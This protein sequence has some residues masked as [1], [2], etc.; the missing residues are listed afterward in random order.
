[1]AI[2]SSIAASRAGRLS[3]RGAPDK[4][5]G[6]VIVVVAIDI[7]DPHDGAPCQFGM[8]CLAIPGGSRRAAS[9]TISM[10]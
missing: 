4:F 9:E 10:A 6:D 8:A 3:C 7:P 2:S 1:L 5:L